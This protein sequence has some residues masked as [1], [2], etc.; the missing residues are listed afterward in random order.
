MEELKNKLTELKSRLESIKEKLNLPALKEE[1]DLMEVESS[2]PGFWDNPKVSQQTMSRLG[3][4]RGDLK[5]ASEFDARLKE[6]EELL[7]MVSENVEEPDLLIDLSKEL[8]TAEKD[9]SILESKTYLSG[10]YDRGDAILSVHAGQGG[11]EA[12]DWSSV[13]QRM[14]LKYAQKRGWKTDVI[15]LIS[16]DEAGIKSVSMRISGSCAYGYLRREA[17]IH[18][19][20]RLSPFNAQ[21]LRQTSFAKVEVLPLIEDEKDLE[22]NPADL[23]FDSYRAGGHGGQNV[24]KVETAVRIKH[25]PTGIITACQSQRYQEQNRK[26][27]IQMLAAKLWELEETRRQQQ[28]RTLKGENATPTWGRQI[29]SYVLHPYKMVK[30]L[31]TGWETSNAQAVLD[32]DLDGLIES[33]LSLKDD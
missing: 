3:E 17:G 26:I 5:M 8:E 15:D 9:L 16:G 1:A 2:Q 25:K 20:V 13:L 27:A 6:F 31:R 10:R 4:L 7:K 11:T 28:Q 29:R 18:R 33:A 32:G 23:E 21:S 22:I 12:M 30:D 14:Y 24:N 19:L